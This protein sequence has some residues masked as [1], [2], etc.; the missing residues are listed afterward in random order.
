MLDQIRDSL[1]LADDILLIPQYSEIIHRSG[2]KSFL[3]VTNIYRHPL[4]RRL[5]IQ[6]TENIVAQVM[7]HQ[8]L[9]HP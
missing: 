1:I 3:P 8:W 4:F 9:D 6:V 2:S 7:A 5:W